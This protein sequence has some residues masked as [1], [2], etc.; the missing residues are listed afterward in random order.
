[1]ITPHIDALLPISELSTQF[2]YSFTAFLLSRINN[3]LRHLFCFLI[4]KFYKKIICVI[5]HQ[6]TAELTGSCAAEGVGG[7][8]MA[9]VIVLTGRAKDTIVLS[10]GE[11][12]EPGAIEDAAVCSPLIKFCVLLGQDRRSLG[13]LIVPDAEAFE[14]EGRFGPPGQHLMVADAKGYSS[15]FCLDSKQHC[16]EK[17]S[18]TIHQQHDQS[19][20][21]G[22]RMSLHAATV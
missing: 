14:E 5:L 16:R 3:G 9:G 13:A 7:S 19:L 18:I 21:R 12:I 22:C 20:A 4:Q 2:T 1:M 10:S 6:W 17:P 15:L 11:N 8:N